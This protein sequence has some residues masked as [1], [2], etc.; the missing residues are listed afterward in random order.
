MMHPALVPLDQMQSVQ[1]HI[2]GSR[3]KG[4]EDH[5]LLLGIIPLIEIV[6]TPCCNGIPRIQNRHI[7]FSAIM[8]TRPNP[9]PG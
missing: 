8:I 7:D 5:Y 2:K 1:Q 4:Q 3:V 9:E 6:Q